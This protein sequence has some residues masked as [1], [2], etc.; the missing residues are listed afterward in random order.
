MASSQL[1]SI[2]EKFCPGV[3]CQ[4]G[5]VQDVDFASEKLLDVHEETSAVEKG[6]TLL[7]SNDQIYVTVGAM[8]ATSNRTRET[9]PFDTVLA[10]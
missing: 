6:S 7:H 9:D 1:S 10:R 2:C 5:F 4:G 3:I 8:L